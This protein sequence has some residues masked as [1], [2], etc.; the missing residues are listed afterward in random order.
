MIKD[1]E[2]IIKNYEKYVRLLTSYYQSLGNSLEESQK[3]AKKE[4]QF[5]LN[6]S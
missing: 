5:Y 3:G 4:L 2:H 6:Q 1:K